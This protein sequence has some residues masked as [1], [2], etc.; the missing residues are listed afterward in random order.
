MVDNFCAIKLTCY[1]TPGR[2]DLDVSY[3]VAWFHKMENIFN[4]KRVKTIFTAVGF[5]H[6]LEAG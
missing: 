1:H 2:V 5:K 4:T 6:G 3:S